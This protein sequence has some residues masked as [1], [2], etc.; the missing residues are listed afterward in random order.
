MEHKSRHTWV[1]YFDVKQFEN[2]LLSYSMCVCVRVFVWNC[3]NIYTKWYLLFRS[4]CTYHTYSY[5]CVYKCICWLDWQLDLHQLF[6]VH[7]K[8]WRKINENIEKVKIRALTRFMIFLV[9]W[10]MCMSHLLFGGGL[11][12]QISLAAIFFVCLLNTWNLFLFFF[13]ISFS[14][15]VDFLFFE[16]WKRM[17]NADRTS[18]HN[19]QLQQ[20][21]QFQPP[22]SSQQQLHYS[23]CY[24]YY[25]VL[26]GRIPPVSSHDISE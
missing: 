11:S 1:L 23:C 14:F 6:I 13:L 18:Q 7:I 19:K 10:K 25:V 2:I 20:N 4:Q 3:F 17:D 16:M 12:I 9:W 22:S 24:Y 26:W 15:P 5:R 8:H 21:Q